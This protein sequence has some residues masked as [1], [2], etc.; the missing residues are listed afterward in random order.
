MFEIF[1][2]ISLFRLIVDCVDL[3]SYILLL[4]FIYA[5]F[6]DIILPTKVPLGGKKRVGWIRSENRSNP[7][8]FWD[9]YRSDSIFSRRPP[10]RSNFFGGIPVL[11]NFLAGQPIRPVPSQK[12]PGV[13]TVYI[14][15]FGNQSSDWVLRQRKMNTYLEKILTELDHSR[16]FF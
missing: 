15:V 6:H 7:I 2:I 14:S 8:F 10:I 13:H 16:P 11:S 3:I 12:N 1:I 9:C 4:Y 5:L